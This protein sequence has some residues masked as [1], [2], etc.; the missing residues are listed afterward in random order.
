MVVFQGFGGGGRN[1]IYFNCDCG[2]PG[3]VLQICTKPRALCRYGRN[4]KHT[5]EYFPDLIEKRGRCN[6]VTTELCDDQKELLKEPVN[7]KIV[8]RWGIRIREDH[9]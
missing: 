1:H 4:T 8:T 2:E 3:H 7:V 6:L 5:T 9:G